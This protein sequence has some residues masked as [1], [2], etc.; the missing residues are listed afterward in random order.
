ME[1][2]YVVL[3]ELVLLDVLVARFTIVEMDKHVGK[4][5]LKVALLLL[6]HLIHA[7]LVNLLRARVINGHCLSSHNIVVLLL[8][9]LLMI[10][11]LVSCSCSGIAGMGNSI[12]HHLRLHLTS[13][14]LLLVVLVVGLL[15]IVHL[16]LLLMVEVTANR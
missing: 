13:V 14:L 16:L 6:T 2:P 10:L 4:V 11:M 15:L 5:V 12:C 3:D 1:E 7:F 8:M 9:M